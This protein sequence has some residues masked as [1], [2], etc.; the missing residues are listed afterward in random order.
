MRVDRVSFMGISTVKENSMTPMPPQIQKCHDEWAN[1]TGGQLNIVALEIEELLEEV[2][3][4]FPPYRWLAW[5]AWKLYLLTK[6][7]RKR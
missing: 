4:A 5:A 6:P 3:A 1:T 2:K 7:H